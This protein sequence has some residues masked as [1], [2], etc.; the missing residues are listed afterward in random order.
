MLD[1]VSKSIYNYKKVEG[2]IF[3]D[4]KNY[5]FSTM[6][7]SR[8][9]LDLEKYDFVEEEYFI[10]GIANLYDGDDDSLKIVENNLEYCNRILVRRPR[11]K[12]SGRVYI[13][14]MNA[15]NGY[16]IEDLWRRAFDFILE[17]NHAYIG[18][19][20]KPIN[21]QALKYFNPSRYKNLNW[22]NGKV[23]CMPVVPN[24]FLSISGTEE[25]LVW[26]IISQ[27]GGICRENPELVLGNLK[28]ENIYLSGQSQSGVYL[29]TYVNHFDRYLNTKDGSNLFDGYFSL[30]SGGYHRSLR[31]NEDIFMGIVK[32]FEAEIKA[33]FI[34]LNSEGDYGLF[35][36][37]SGVIRSKNSD[38]TLD[39]RRYYEVAGAPHTN[40]ASPV[41]PI[42]EEIVKTKCPPRILDKD[43]SYRLNDFPLEYYITALMD[44]LHAWATAGV[45]PQKIDAFKL[46]AD[47]KIMR[48]EYGNAL[49][50][51]RSPFVEAPKA[52]YFG[53]A[54]AGDVNGTI[55]FF[56]SD[57]MSEIYGNFDNYLEKFKQEALKNL[58][59]GLISKSNYEKM[60]A[61]SKNI[62]K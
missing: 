32:S 30:V 23:T 1:L 45:V 59:A 8:E 58:E 42:N 25:G 29:N 37:I 13:D 19:T 33:P 51:I 52:R 6:K 44:K 34:T 36:G 16:D 26:D 7:K 14:I 54:T 55:E 38:S 20:S 11:H 15:T 43:Y 21:V 18:I 62:N 61:W 5:P 56:S 39:K 9:K 17:N 53:N 40:A 35:E 10:H 50:G 57:K 24:E 3:S 28:P 46:D 2:P 48:D 4:D 41:L 47:K 49:G 22:S 60:L 12:F 27:V 31:Q